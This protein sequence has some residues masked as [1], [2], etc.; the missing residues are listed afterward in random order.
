[1]SPVHTTLQ[2]IGRPESQEAPRTLI[3]Q[4]ITSSHI[5]F[6]RMSSTMIRHAAPEVDDPLFPYFVAGIESACFISML[7]ETR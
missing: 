6:F 2:S 3:G 1:M 7:L 4:N 5:Y